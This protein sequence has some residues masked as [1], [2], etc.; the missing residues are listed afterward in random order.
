MLE[1]AY[2]TAVYELVQ[3]GEKLPDVLSRLEVVLT[4]RGHVKLTEKIYKALLQYAEQK[5]HETTPVVT[6]AKKADSAALEKE[7]A[8]ALTTLSAVGAPHVVEDEAITGGFITYYAGNQIDA[9][10]KTKLL[11]LYNHITK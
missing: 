9:S 3:K 2:A 5:E 11:S 7:I 8:T 6:V 10:Y 1:T 4:E